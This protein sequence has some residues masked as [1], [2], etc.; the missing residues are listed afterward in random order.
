[1]TIVVTGAAGFV[2][3]ALAKQLLAEGVDRLIL[4]D[5][6]LSADAALQESSDRSVQWRVG[7]VA[8]ADFIRS[9][10]P[11]D[12]TIVFHLAGIVSGE[13][14]ADFDL[15]M[16]VNLDG[17]RH[18]LEA[19]R[20]LGSSVRLVFSSSIAVYGEP[21]PDTIDD[22]TLP[23]PTLSYGAQKLAFEQLVNDYSRRG[24]LDGRTVRFPGVVVRPPHPN[25]ALSAFTSDIIREPL[26]G[27]AITAP[28]SPQ[29]TL[30]I[31]SVET[32]V[33]NLLHAARLD[34]ARLGQ[35]RA[36]LLPAVCASIAEIVDITSRF[37]GRDLS[38]LIQYAPDPKIEPLFARWPRRFTA[39]RGFDLGFH[40]DPSLEAIVRGYVNQI[41]SSATTAK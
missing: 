34:S 1:M 6:S 24:F 23:V 14:E 30:W 8:Q 39:R 28:V 13:A 12:T 17:G 31:A 38:A 22:A 29:G 4:V 41:A 10:I 26:A 33:R 35:Q 19:C 15:G 9:A 16:R 21:L 2:G 11:Q 40:V 3:T 5:R 36:V 32:C 7:D 20:A 27:R 37:A 25:G 18:V